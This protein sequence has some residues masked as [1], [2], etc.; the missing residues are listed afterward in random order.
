MTIGQ[1]PQLVREITAAV[2]QAV[3]IPVIPKLTPNVVNIAEI[4][5]AAV[6]GGAD[7]LCAI[8]TVGPGYYTIDGHP[9]L[10][11]TYGGMSGKGILPIGLKCVREIAAAVDV[12]IIGCSDINSAEDVQAYQ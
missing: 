2:K 6:D 9:V 4:A 5:Q 7:A 12:L 8:N 1:D 11:N 10:T 3:D